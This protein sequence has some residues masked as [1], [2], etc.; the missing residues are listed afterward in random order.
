MF[1]EFKEDDF[2]CKMEKKKANSNGENTVF[3]PKIP[4]TLLP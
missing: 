2:K 1:G 4:H 3:I